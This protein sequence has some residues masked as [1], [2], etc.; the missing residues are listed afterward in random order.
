[1]TGGY[2]LWTSVLGW[3]LEVLITFG[4]VV[5]LAQGVAMV[6]HLRVQREDKP[7]G[8]LWWPA[9]Q[10]QWRR[11]VTVDVY[12]L[13]LALSAKC[14]GPMQGGPEVTAGCVSEHSGPMCYGSGPFHRPHVPSVSGNV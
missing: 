10:D 4:S 2:Y 6:L 12:L 7:W 13:S 3:K 1:V 8:W 14:L 9:L 5:G 11:V